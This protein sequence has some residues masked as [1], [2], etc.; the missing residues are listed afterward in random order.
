MDR[1][2]ARCSARETRLA[3]RSA[4]PGWKVCRFGAK[5]SYVVPSISARSPNSSHA[6]RSHTNCTAPF[7]PHRIELRRRNQATEHTSEHK[8]EGRARGRVRGAGARRVCG[9]GSTAWAGARGSMGRL[10]G[11]QPITNIINMLGVELGRIRT[12]A[13]LLPSSSLPLAARAASR[14]AARR[15]GAPP[16]GLLGLPSLRL[17][18]KRGALPQCPR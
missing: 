2:M 3:S 11:K 9:V 1:G 10:S 4:K 6:C 5:R 17:A 13:A 7:R 15:S 18:A 16:L 14:P 8:T 12:N